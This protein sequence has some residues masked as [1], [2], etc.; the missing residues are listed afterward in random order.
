MADDRFTWEFDPKAIERSFHELR[1]RLRK[2]ADQ[3]RFTKVR[4]SWRGKPL[5]PDIP[6]TSLLAANGLALL[7]TGPI[8]VLIV[9]LGLK[10]FLEVQ[11]IHESA[12]RVAEGVELFQRG[13]VDLAEGKYREALAMNPG[14]TSAHYHLGVLLRVTGRR[15]EAIDS[16]ER[17]ARDKGHPDAARAEDAL[18]RMRRGPRA[19]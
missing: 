5:L 13:E 16:F 8:Q 2:L 3:A 4:F 7:L 15:D 12:E 9:N 11:L 6:M 1:E 18:E 14:D 10:A 17:A 19:I